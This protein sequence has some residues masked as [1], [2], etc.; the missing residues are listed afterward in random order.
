MARLSGGGVKGGF[1]PLR[2]KKCE[3]DSAIVNF[4]EL[5]LCNSLIDQLLVCTHCRCM[6]IL[7]IDLMNR[8]QTPHPSGV[9][10]MHVMQQSLVV[11]WENSCLSSGKP[12]FDSRP[13]QE[14]SF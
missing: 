5:F 13:T 1:P 8:N 2:G 3:F 7:T 10:V 4:G 14:L 12:E 9:K 11:Q 6:H